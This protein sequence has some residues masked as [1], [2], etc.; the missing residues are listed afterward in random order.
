MQ[1]NISVAPNLLLE[2]AASCSIV[3]DMVDTMLHFLETCA[4]RET[5]HTRRKIYCHVSVTKV[6]NL[7]DK[8]FELLT[9]ALRL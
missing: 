6:N 9:N 3:K 8:I 1:T 7:G 5:N 4:M 2:I